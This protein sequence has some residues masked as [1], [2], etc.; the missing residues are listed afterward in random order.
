MVGIEEEKREWRQEIMLDGYK[1]YLAAL[2]AFLTALGL[3]IS[4]YLNEGVIEPTALITAFI[5]LSLLFLRQS[6]RRC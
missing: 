3:F 4:K 5:A 6:I 2:A 1:T